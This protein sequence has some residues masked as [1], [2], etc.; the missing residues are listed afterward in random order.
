MLG[1]IRSLLFVPGTRQDRFEKAMQAGADAVAFDLEDA[2]E[3]AHK[4]RARALIAEFFAK[5]AS[6]AALR[7]VRFNAV[8]TELGAADL[9]YFRD[10]EGYDGIL[11]PKVETSGALETVA[12]AFAGRRPPRPTP[13]L[14]PLVESPR[15]ILRVADIASAAAPVAALLFGAEDLTAQL[16]VP[17]TV[18]GEELLVARGQVVLAAAAVGAEP[19]DAVFT[20]LDDLG[21]LRRDADRA[22][23]V[24]FRGKMAIHPRQVPVINDVF[25]PSAVEVERARRVV[26]AF[27]RARAAGEGVARMDDQMVEL[28]VVERARRTLALA[29]AVGRVLSD[30]AKR[31]E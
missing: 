18:E 5:P 10:I 6:T 28:P 1:P 7:L 20:N 4:E 3:A 22:R 24:G 9:A 8:Q 11:L 29:A 21:A 12:R 26:E 14:L 16:S 15:A 13:P 2:V 19:I 17:R 27:E 30:P 23:A 31:A 25:T